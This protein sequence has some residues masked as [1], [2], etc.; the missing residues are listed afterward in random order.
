MHLV[1]PGAPTLAGPKVGKT[2]VD[3]LAT[4]LGNLSR[5]NMWQLHVIGERY[6]RVLYIR[7]Y[8]YYTVYGRTAVVH[9]ND[10]R[11]YRDLRTFH[12][13]KIHNFMPL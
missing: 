7:P 5:S 1:L 12:F 4:E 13:V 9:Y 8:C 10:G 6:S 3:V 2:L 11:F